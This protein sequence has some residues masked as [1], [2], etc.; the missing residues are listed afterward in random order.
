MVIFRLFIT[1]HYFESLYII[2]GTKKPEKL[3]FN[4]KGMCMGSVP[5]ST[6]DRQCGIRQL[7][8]VRCHSLYLV[9]IQGMGGNHHF[10]GD[11]AM[12]AP[13]DPSN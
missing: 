7:A 2:R 6:P 3:Q 11:V 8:L 1:L 4:S 9:Q 10:I 5:P 12:K 13:E